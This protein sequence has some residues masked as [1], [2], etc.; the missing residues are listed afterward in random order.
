[1]TFTLDYEVL[2]NF[3][4]SHSL[5]VNERTLHALT[6]H[7]LHIICETAS[8]ENVVSCFIKTCVAFSSTPQSFH[9]TNEMKEINVATNGVCLALKCK[10]IFLCTALWVLNTFAYSWSWNP[11]LCTL[12]EK[13][14]LFKVGQQLHL[15]A[16]SSMMTAS[17]TKTLKYCM[18]TLI[19]HAFWIIIGQ[20]LCLNRSTVGI[21]YWDQ[22]VWWT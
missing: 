7:E 6:L 16:C 14:E 9:Y 20:T 8:E 18:N 21:Y 12:G 5:P 17:M 4:V 15:L 19:H 3:Q 1:M 10:S 13:L 2:V 22:V 11:P